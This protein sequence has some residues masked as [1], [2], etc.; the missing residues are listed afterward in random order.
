MKTKIVYV[1]VSQEDDSYYEMLLL[2]H[3]SLRL[4]HP[5]ED[6]AVFIIMDQDTYGRLK[7][8]KASILDDSIP[9]VV[10]I[11]EEYSVMQRSRFLKTNLRSFIKGDFLY[12]DTDTIICDRLDEID[13]VQADIAMVADLNAPFPLTDP[14]TL[15]KC[16]EAGFQGMEGQPYF[17][18]GVMLVRDGDTSRQLFRQW[19]TLWLES[20]ARGVPNDQPALGEVNHRMGYPIHELPGEWNCQFKYSSGL[21]Y[22]KKA[23][24]LHS[25]SPLSPNSRSFFETELLSRIKQSGAI[26]K[27]EESII[28]GTPKNIATFF[29]QTS[30][31][32][33][34][35]LGSDMFRVFI[36][37]ASIFR[38]SSLVAVFIMNWKH[39]LFQRYH[40]N[41][42]K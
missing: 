28:S 24:I 12:I 25:F 31:K 37:D 4:Y 16:V 26:D 29:G 42:D 17:N 8:I 38:L 22:L 19:H 21:R 9:I 27:T 30:D 35:F 3:H 39:F 1:L 6:A 23:K 11:P 36:E 10:N 7:G 5:K 33:L 13:N 14:N 32:G 2:S 34:Q 18:S 15:R 40:A 20:L 41:K